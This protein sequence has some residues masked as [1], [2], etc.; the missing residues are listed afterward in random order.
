LVLV[1]LVFL[2]FLGYLVPTS[3]SCLDVGGPLSSGHAVN[4]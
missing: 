4:F 3:E 1:F 2:E